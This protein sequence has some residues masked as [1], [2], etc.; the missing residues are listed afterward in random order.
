M[1]LII[2]TNFVKC[3]SIKK[4]EIIITQMHVK[5]KIVIFFNKEEI[6]KSK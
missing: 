6:Y 1:L 5:P 3:E 2:L 4:K